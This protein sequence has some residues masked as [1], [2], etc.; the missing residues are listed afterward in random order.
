M[1]SVQNCPDEQSFAPDPE[2][3]QSIVLHLRENRSSLSQDGRIVFTILIGLFMAM[4]ILFA[5]KG[6]V[7]VPV[8]ALTTMALLVGALEWHKRSQPAAE[9]LTITGNS[10]RWT[11]RNTA[12]VVLPLHATRLLRDEASPARLRLFLE[13][14]AV[15]IE[16]GRCLSLAEK[17]AV[18]PLIARHVR[19]AGA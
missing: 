13:C 8:Y 6:E 4:A 5:A 2:R 10:L 12:P 18:I 7:L 9:C 19:E 3:A 1:Y 14:R 15:R 11:S 16:I 17:R